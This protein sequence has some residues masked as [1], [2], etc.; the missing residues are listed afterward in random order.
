[1]TRRAGIY[2][3]VSTAMQKERHSL[4]AQEAFLREYARNN[5]MTVIEHY[6]DAGISAKDT[7]RP[8]LQR[9]MQDCTQRKLDAVL[10]LELDRLTRNVKDMLTLSEFFRD[11]DVEYIEVAGG[12]TDMSTPENEMFRTIQS[13]VSQYERKHTGLRI[14]RTKQHRAR[15]GKRTGGGCPFGYTSQ[16]KLEVEGKRAGLSESA[17][18]QRAA[19]TCPERGKLYIVPEEAALVKQIFDMYH[20]VNSIRK[21]VTLLNAAG[22]RTHS[23]KYWTQTSVRRILTNPVYIGK[24][25]ASGILAEGEQP[26]IISEDVF[27][28]VQ[29]QLPKSA[30]KPTKAGYIYLF[31]GVIR[32]GYCGAPMCGEATAAHH[33]YKCTRKASQGSAACQGQYW[34][35]DFLESYLIDYLKGVSENGDFLFDTRNTIDDIRDKLAVRDI[36]PELD[37][38]D[39]AIRQNKQRITILL[40]KLQDGIIDDDDFKPRRDQLKAD[41]AGLETTRARVQEE[42]ARSQEYLVLLEASFDEMLGFWQGWD[43]LTRE[44]QQKRIRS[45]VEEIVVSKDTN[46]IHIKLIV[47]EGFHELA[48]SL[49]VPT[50]TEDGAKNDLWNS[51][52]CGKLYFSLYPPQQQRK[53]TA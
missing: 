8:A 13:S 35:A 10:V 19:Q 52:L 28:A 16:G 2:T 46:N 31:S 17:A 18:M 44:Q 48:K 11:H 29:K 34:R 6:Q 40:D 7:N 25:R 9:L 36:R 30:L 39:N 20:S 41:I 24:L 49:S 4:P 53:K 23:G 1:M 21:T 14:Q 43:T 50:T 47:G 32:C 38:L 3:R 27:R 51:L 22:Q 5:N 12:N 45:I 42:Y 33:Y 37:R 26:A 15:Q